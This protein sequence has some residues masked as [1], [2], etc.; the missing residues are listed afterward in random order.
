[1]SEEKNNVQAG[2]D[3]QAPVDSSQ[4]STVPNP[5]LSK[6][7]NHVVM[8]VLSYLGILIIIPYLMSKDEPFVKFHIKQGLILVVAWFVLWAARWFMMFVPFMYLI[9]SVLNLILFIFVIIGIVNVLQNKQTP[10][11][12][13]GHLGEMFKI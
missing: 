8:G 10:L 7:Q 3:N 6:E 11:P 12:F 5:A 13:I 4:N 1:M 9:I 2:P